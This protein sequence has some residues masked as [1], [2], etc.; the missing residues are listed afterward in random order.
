MSHVS[1]YLPGFVGAVKV[2]CP[3]AGTVGSMLVPLT[4]TVWSA[5]SS[6]LTVTFAPGF[7]VRGAKA[8]PEITSM[9]ACCVLP[10]PAPDELEVMDIDGDGVGAEVA[11][12]EVEQ[13]V[14]NNPTTPR[15]AAD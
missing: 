7:T 11:V 5:E 9:L 8:K 15:R 4:L 13:A 6:L 3:P 12:E 1:G 14:A 10:W 2:T